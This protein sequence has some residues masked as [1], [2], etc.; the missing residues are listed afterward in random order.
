M[1]RKKIEEEKP[2][3]SNEIEAPST[4][5]F[6]VDP[7]SVGQAVYD[8]L[9]EKGIPVEAANFDAV[10]RNTMI[11]NLRQLIENKDLM[12]PRHKEDTLTMTFTDKLIKELISMMET[13]TQKDRITYQS[14]AP[15]DDT[16]MALSM[17]CKGVAQQ[18]A[19]MDMVAI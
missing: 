5:R 2:K 3:D 14:K 16:V 11:I 12:I 6:V 17:A 9:R 4:I 13:K 15:H 10:S 1:F 19:F 8:G 7:S 18:R